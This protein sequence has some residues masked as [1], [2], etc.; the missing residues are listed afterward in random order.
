VEEI[1]KNAKSYE[2][3]I[4]RKEKPLNISKGYNWFIFNTNLTFDNY[5]NRNPQKTLICHTFF[6][7][8]S[9]GFDNS[10]VVYL[11]MSLLLYER[12][13]YFIV[14]KFGCDDIP[15]NVNVVIYRFDK[16]SEIKEKKLKGVGKR[17]TGRVRYLIAIF[18]DIDFEY[19]TKRAIL[20]KDYNI[21]NK[22]FY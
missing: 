16:F 19:I 15:I 13:C 2:K 10:K 6:S 3:K 5:Y 20:K 14:K 7:Q 22:Y 21:F 17:C 1:I 18:K 11:N 12:L 4:N 8:R 9:V